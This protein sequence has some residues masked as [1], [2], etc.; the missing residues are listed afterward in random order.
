M[1]P[2]LLPTN[3]LRECFPNIFQ[4][5]LEL[6]GFQQCR[7]GQSNKL[8]GQKKE[9]YLRADVII[10][11]KKQEIQEKICQPPFNIIIG[12]TAIYIATEPY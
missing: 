7:Y 4:T 9:G 11:K 12:I 10:K 3:T 1:L 5:N 6:D 2:N 8:L